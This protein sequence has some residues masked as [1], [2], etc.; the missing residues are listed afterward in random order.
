VSEVHQQST[1]ARDGQ[2][3]PTL[4][5]LK[6]PPMP[7]RRLTGG[8]TGNTRLIPESDLLVKLKPRR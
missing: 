3:A 8:L 2:T 5:Q 7:M 6:E 4:T 1:P